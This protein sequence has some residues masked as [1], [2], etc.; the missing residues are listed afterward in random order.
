[1]LMII[2]EI[3]E[4]VDAGAEDSRLVQFNNGGKTW[5]GIVFG[6]TGPSRY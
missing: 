5:I 1:M 3:F 4:R 2:R 6:D